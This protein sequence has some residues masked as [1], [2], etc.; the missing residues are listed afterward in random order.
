MCVCVFEFSKKN[1]KPGHFEE[2]SIT[3]QTRESLVRYNDF[4]CTDNKLQLAVLDPDSLIITRNDKQLTLGIGLYSFTSAA[5]Y[6]LSIHN[7]GHVCDLHYNEIFENVDMFNNEKF[8]VNTTQPI[9]ANETSGELIN[10]VVDEGRLG[11][12]C[13]YSLHFTLATLLH[14]MWPNG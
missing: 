1:D 2:K 8:D 10:D 9:F 4:I 14:P 7:A 6:K 13:P 11:C 12:C 3:L 5:I